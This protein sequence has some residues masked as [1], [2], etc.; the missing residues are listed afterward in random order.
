MGG[1]ISSMSHF[2][3]SNIVFPSTPIPYTQT[4]AFNTSFQPLLRY[5]APLETSSPITY[6]SHEGVIPLRDRGQPLIQ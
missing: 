1:L 6:S 3:S 2:S 4:K 5:G